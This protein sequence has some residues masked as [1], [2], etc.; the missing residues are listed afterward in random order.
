MNVNWRA[1][2]CGLLAAAV[3]VAVGVFGISRA[4]APAECPDRLPYQPSAY[5]PFGEPMGSPALQ[6]AG[7]LVRSGSTSFGLAAW[8]VWLP[9][10]EVPQASGDPLPDRIVLE[11]GDGTYRAYRRGME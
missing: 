9:E 1:M 7:Q 3:F 10:A 4:L 2:G 8:N 11:C 6:D 5:R